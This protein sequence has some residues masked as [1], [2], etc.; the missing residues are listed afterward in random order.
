[1][2]SSYEHGKSAPY[3]VDWRR[4]C[5]RIYKYITLAFST[6]GFGNGVSWVVTDSLCNQ[7]LTSQECFERAVRLPAALKAAKEAGAGKS[8]SIQ[9]MTAVREKY[10]QMAEKEVIRRAHSKTY[11]QRIKKRCKSVT[12]E[13]EVVPLTEDSDGNGGQDTSTYLSSFSCLRYHPF[14]IISFESQRGQ[15]VLGRHQSPPL[16]LQCRQLT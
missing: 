12:K 4:A 1:L 7:H 15:R 8:D 3:L 14:L 11:I 9:L 10:I 16:V 6:K 13:K 5:E 2:I